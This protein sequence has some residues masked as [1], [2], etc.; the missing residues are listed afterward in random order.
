MGANNFN[1]PVGY[2][3]EPAYPMRGLGAAGR[4]STA[5]LE[6]RSERPR[7]KSIPL[8]RE[9]LNARNNLAILDQNLVKM[10]T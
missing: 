8:A 7:H 6:E 1:R 10:L 2:T 4:F 5:D 9:C 3:R